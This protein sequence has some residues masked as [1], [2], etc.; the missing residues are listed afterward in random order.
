MVKPLRDD[1]MVAFETE[2]RTAE[3]IYTLEQYKKY[4]E[5]SK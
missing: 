1:L 2:N 5:V 4:I 3:F